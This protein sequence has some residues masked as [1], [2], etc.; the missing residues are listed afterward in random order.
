MEDATANGV[1]SHAQRASVRQLG[2][3]ARPAINTKIRNSPAEFE[4]FAVNAI[5]LRWAM[6]DDNDL[7]LVLQDPNDA[8][9][10]MVAEIPNP[11]CSSVAPSPE[12]D[13]FAA[14]RATVIAKLGATS[15][16]FRDVNMPV[17]IVGIAFFDKT[18][19]GGGHAPNGIEL[20]PVLTIRYP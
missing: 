6:E 15:K 5:L 16:T 11:A 18:A 20:H 9:A 3:I 2:K 17:Q 14:A 10:T 13:L 19:H 12:A 7:H 4:R 1:K 8:S